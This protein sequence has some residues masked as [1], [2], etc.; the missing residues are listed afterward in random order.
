MRT[1]SLTSALPLPLEVPHA[2]HPVLKSPL[3]LR[4]RFRLRHQEHRRHDDKPLRIRYREGDG[5]RMEIQLNDDVRAFVRRGIEDGRFARE[6]DA[7]LE[8]LSLWES[9][10]RRRATILA[11]VDRAERS[12]SRGEGQTIESAEAA[13][14]FAEDVKSRAAARRARASYP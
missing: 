6:E 14:R 12:L 9:R 10:E 3:R 2:V 4:M 8:A 5:K 11:A 13:I 7:V 1:W